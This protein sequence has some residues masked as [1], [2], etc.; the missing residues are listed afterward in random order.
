MIQ[1]I[2]DI[3]EE[4]LIAFEKENF[5]EAKALYLKVL[6]ID[7]KHFN[8]NFNLGII[9]SSINE[10][11][12]AMKYFQTA[13]KYN[14]NASKTW[15]LLYN[16]G[17]C[18]LD[19]KKYKESKEL[20]EKVINLK[21]DYIWAYI[22]LGIS[23][24]ELGF[25][26]ESENIYRK[27]IKIDSNI[28]ILNNNLGV[29][30]LNQNRL[31]EAKIFI[32][33]SIEIN[34]D[35][36]EAYANLAL[37][38]DNLG[39]IEKSETFINKA[40]DLNPDK[41]LFNYILGCMKKDMGKYNE[42]LD[43]FNKS[44]SL[45]PDYADAYNNRG[46]TFRI[47]EDF[48]RCEESYKQALNLD[49]N[50]FIAN[51]NLLFLKSS[52]NTDP[53]IHLNEAKNYGK[54]ISAKANKVFSKW[55]CSE[56]SNCLNIG[57][58]SADLRN[59]PVGYFLENIL[60]SIDKSRIKL[61]A[62]SNLKKE[63]ELS[64]RIKPAFS[65]WK[66]I[67]NKSDKDTAELIHDDG[68]HILFDL[69]GHTAKNRLPVFA[70]KPAPIQ[71]T[72]LGYWATTGVA[73]MDY[74]LGDPYRTPYEDKD[75]FTE[76]IWQLPET[77]L[78]FSEPKDKVDIKPLP[79]LSNGFITFGCF[80][81]LTKMTDE[82]VKVRADIL[83]AVPESKLFLK[84]KLLDS[85]QIYTS[86]LDRFAQHNISSDRLILEGKTP[87]KEYFEA[88]NK[89]DIALSPFPYAGSTTSIEGLWMGVPVLTLEGNNCVSNVGDLINQNI[90]L[91]DWI[92][93]DN[94]EYIEKAKK[95]ASGIEYL[96]KLRNNLRKEVLSSP[97]FYSDRFTENFQ[98]ALWTMWEKWKRN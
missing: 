23:L 59:H 73:E 26:K 14:T 95:F 87:R 71:V 58:V 35:Y 11:G 77:S 45:K 64:E 90:G 31:H 13:L 37:V 32:E 92:A 28:P 57:F 40:I 43:C 98:E 36:A 94:N 93:G 46:V 9:F 15:T 80:N 42:A 17:N 66:Q 69:S 30:M 67:I 96:S 34:P 48:K 55:N 33:K 39:E 44:I 54:R 49:S 3:Y 86:V 52:N 25:F 84:S 16:L 60:N 1:P 72:W 75:H 5:M 29:L 89:I 78:C 38:L 4:A 47:L 85:D 70:Y 19:I 83:K 74:I 24:K 51:S 68:I 10:P 82:V 22:N 76:T 79:A 7:Y 20:F 2:N 12:E 81:N 91:S 63:D 6:K 56:D 97:L 27:A 53:L 65:S 62:Y 18:F 8:S 41:A 21:P 88:Y 50:H 61:F